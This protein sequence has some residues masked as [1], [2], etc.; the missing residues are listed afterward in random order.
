[1]E[2]SVQFMPNPAMFGRVGS[3]SIL[4]QINR[5]LDA[6]DTIG[7][8]DWKLPI[9][10]ECESLYQRFPWMSA[11][12]FE[13][14]PQ[15]TTA[16]TT[17]LPTNE[18][19]VLRPGTSSR[20]TSF[21]QSSDNKLSLQQLLGAG[22]DKGSYQHEVSHQQEKEKTGSF[23]ST[24]V[25]DDLSLQRLLSDGPPKPM[26]V[27]SGAT[28]TS[29]DAA[30]REQETSVVGSFGSRTADKSR[31]S[32]LYKLLSSS[33][34]ARN[35]SPEVGEPPLS[36]YKKRRKDKKLRYTSHPPGSSASDIYQ[37]SASNSAVPTLKDTLPPNAPEPTLVPGTSEETRV[38]A[39]TS[40]SDTIKMNKRQ[41]KKKE[42]FD[43]SGASKEQ[44]KRKYTRRKKAQSEDDGSE[45]EV[46][47]I[48]DTAIELVPRQS[49]NANGSEADSNGELIEV[50]KYLI[51]WKGYEDESWDTWEPEENLQNA[52]LKI[53]EFWSNKQK[54]GPAWRPSR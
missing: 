7:R 28:A 14:T 17:A 30:L 15:K 20:R 39:F 41:R 54:F 23:Q 53:E 26:L 4:D 43:P 32:N 38:P 50:R 51:K 37:P 10:L 13:K 2:K 9:E 6:P 25:D 40:V 16:E 34:V 22:V 12:Y 29:L 31:D 47:Y 36:V 48:L 49:Q 27:E 44:K 18:S 52:R 3:S 33:E 46:D 35:G 1:M 21:S 11:D 5:I 42:T 19:I 8:D 45:Y 24:S